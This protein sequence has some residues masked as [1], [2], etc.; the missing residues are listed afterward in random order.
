MLALI[1]H[2]D[3]YGRVAYPKQHRGA[4]VPAV[5]LGA[6]AAAC[7]RTCL[8]RAVRPTL[9]EAA[10]SGLPVIA[11]DSGGPNDII[12]QCD[13][14]VLVNPVRPMRSRKPR[15]TCSAIPSAGSVMPTTA[16][17]RARPSTGRGTCSTTIA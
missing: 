1:D 16:A 17:A 10:A 5:C 15:S 14:E 2:Y 11:T 7:S 8:Q 12:E 13:N 9:L 6:R 3:L 4:D